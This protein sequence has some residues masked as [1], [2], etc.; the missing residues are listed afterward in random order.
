MGKRPRVRCRF[1][2]V[3]VTPSWLTSWSCPSTWSLAVPEW[4]RPSSAFAVPEIW[5]F[6]I[7]LVDRNLVS[8][9]EWSWNGKVKTCNVHDLLR[10][11]CLKVAFKEKFLHVL[12]SRGAQEPINKEQRLV[13]HGSSP[14]KMHHHMESA[15]L[16]RSVFSQ[17]GRLPFDYKLLKVL[18][19]V[20]GEVHEVDLGFLEISLDHQVNSRYL[21]CKV[22]SFLTPTPMFIPQSLPLF[23]NLQTLIIKHHTDI[24]APFEI[25]KM[26]QLRHFLVSEVYL[27]DPPSGDKPIDLLVLKN[28]QT[29]SEVRNFRLSEDVCKRIPTIKKF[30][31][32]YD[33]SSRDEA[34]SIDL[35][36]S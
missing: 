30:H 14:L 27:P 25:W 5:D 4:W 20:D 33:D 23:W 16:S 3:L 34:S 29:L 28:L 6:D 1:I 26:P 19:Q 18:T 22:R 31:V 35:V 9:R 21:H 12:K 13:I 32:E 8:V 24:F 2:E 17:G 36:K 10:E 7:D 15:L 11:L